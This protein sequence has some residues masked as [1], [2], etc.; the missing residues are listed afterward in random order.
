[1]TRRMTKRQFIKEISKDTRIKTEI[2]EI[3]IDRA[4]DIMIE[5]LVNDTKFGILQVFGSNSKMRKGAILP[6]NSRNT[7]SGVLADH[8]ILKMFPS[9]TV[10]TLFKLQQGRFADKPYIVNRD[11]WQ[12]AYKWAIENKSYTVKVFSE[13]NLDNKTPIFAKNPTSQSQLSENS[14]RK[15]NINASENKNNSTSSASVDSIEEI[16]EDFNPFLDDE[17]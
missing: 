15:D 10:K 7:V 13:D 14:S 4:I 16:E 1:M 2:V 6:K 8:K 3:I 11:N 9:F 5:Q 12:S 17:D